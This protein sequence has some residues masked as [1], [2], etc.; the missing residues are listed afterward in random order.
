MKGVRRLSG[1]LSVAVL[2]SCLTVTSVF[3]AP[4]ADDLKQQKCPGVS[5]NYCG[6]PGQTLFLFASQEKPSCR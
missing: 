4:S 2:A 1:A 5:D 3:A 6:S